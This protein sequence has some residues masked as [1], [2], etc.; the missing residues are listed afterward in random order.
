MFWRIPT[1]QMNLSY[2]T[3]PQI[4]KHS[5]QVSKVYFKVVETS[6]R[7]TR[8]MSILTTRLLPTHY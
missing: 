7:V 3:P 1:I 5:S 6:S 8:E 4:S 2:E